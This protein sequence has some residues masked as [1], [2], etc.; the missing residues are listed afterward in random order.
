MHTHY[1]L[2][3]HLNLNVR[4]ILWVLRGKISWAVADFDIGFEGKGFVGIGL[5]I[6]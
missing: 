6:S 2:T 5:G 4:G 3:V 1:T